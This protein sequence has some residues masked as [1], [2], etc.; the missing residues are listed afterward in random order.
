M[1]KQAPLVSS[2]NDPQKKQSAAD[3]WLLKLSQSPNAAKD[4]RRRFAT[5]VLGYS[6]IQFLQR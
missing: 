3:P 4:R 1:F 6:L 5:L 2:L